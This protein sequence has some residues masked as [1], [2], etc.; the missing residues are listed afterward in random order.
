MGTSASV[1]CSNP[2]KLTTKDIN[3]AILLYTQLIYNNHT[4]KV[5]CNMI[6]QLIMLLLKSVRIVM[7]NYYL[8][9]KKEQLFGEN[10]INYFQ[11]NGYLAQYQQ[12]LIQSLM[13]YQKPF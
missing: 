3:N 9:M 8:Y 11:K 12:N 5:H 7:K 13:I 10:I 1:V 2:N 4:K 6:Y